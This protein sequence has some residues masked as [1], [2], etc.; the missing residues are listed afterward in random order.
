MGISTNNTKAPSFNPYA[1]LKAAQQVAAQALRR[2]AASEGFATA[3]K[4]IFDGDQTQI[5]LIQ[6]QLINQ[7]DLGLCYAITNQQTLN[8]AAAGYSNTGTSNQPTIYI[9]EAHLNFSE[10]NTEAIATAARLLLEETGHH[11]DYLL[12]AKVDS[13]GDEGQLFAASVLGDDLSEAQRSKIAIENDHS[14]IKTMGKTVEIEAANTVITASPGSYSLSSGKLA[15]SVSLQNPSSQ[16]KDLILAAY[17]S[18]GALIGWQIAK[19]AATLQE[20]VYSGSFDFAHPK[21]KRISLSEGITLRAWQG[22]ASKQFKSTLTY[23]TGNL[24]RGLRGFAVNSM[25][26][27]QSNTPSLQLDGNISDGSSLQNF[28]GISVATNLKSGVLSL[29]GDA[30]GVITNLDSKVTL[31]LTGQP[32][33]SKFSYQ[34][35]ADS[36]ESWQALTDT[37]LRKL[38]SGNYLIRARVYVS[39]SKKGYST[40]LP[41]TVNNSGNSG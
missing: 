31:Q 9:N 14:T 5:N 32:S 22:T 34:I 35:S 27:P 3:V 19:S 6:Q 7:S 25:T 16:G 13:P 4:D 10:G 26:A 15:Y 29:V 30:D 21:V 23:G 2:Y 33:R 11:I 24:K 12:N 8:G 20:P 38:A 1:N 17:S 39:P 18:S 41:I 40:V 37:D 28:P 36:G